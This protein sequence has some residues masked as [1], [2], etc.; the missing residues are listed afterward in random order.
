MLHKERCQSAAPVALGVRPLLQPRDC[1]DS[2]RAQ[3][4]PMYGAPIRDSG[5]LGCKRYSHIVEIQ[6]YFVAWIDGLE[7][8]LFYGKERLIARDEA[9]KTC[10]LLWLSN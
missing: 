1:K 7:H 9:G 6:K 8:G 3:D 5:G 10:P 4:A 2:R